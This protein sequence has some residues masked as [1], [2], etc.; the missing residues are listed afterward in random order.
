MFAPLICA[1]FGA[2]A[3]AFTAIGS[4]GLRHSISI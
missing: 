1:L 4:V 3:A 2:A